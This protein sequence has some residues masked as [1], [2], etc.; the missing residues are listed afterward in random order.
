MKQLRIAL[1]PSEVIHVKF[2]QRYVHGKTSHYLNSKPYEGSMS[3]TKKVNDL[4]VNRP[5]G[6]RFAMHA[7]R[8]SA[9]YW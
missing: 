9:A 1:I 2:R 5:F 6:S 8:V 4:L 3:L 7:A